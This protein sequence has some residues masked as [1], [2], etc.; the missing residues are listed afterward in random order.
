MFILHTH[1]LNKKVRTLALPKVLWWCETKKIYNFFMLGKWIVDS[2]LL[3]QQ[4]PRPLQPPKS[5]TGKTF[6]LRRSFSFF[7]L[8]TQWLLSLF[9]YY[10]S[11]YDLILN[12]G[13]IP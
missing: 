13:I 5:S 12:V 7:A 2:E 3:R 9:R 1:V 4:L 8:L 6:H 10:A 11:D